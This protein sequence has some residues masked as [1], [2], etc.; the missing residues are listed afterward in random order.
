M[1]RRF[2]VAITAGLT[3]LLAQSPVAAVETE[4]PISHIDRAM[5]LLLAPAATERDCRDGFISLLDALTAVAPAAPSAEACQTRLSEARTRIARTSILDPQ[6]DTLIRDCYRDL[7]R[8]VPFRVPDGVRT[9]TEAVAYC[10]TGLESAKG[11]LRKGAGDEAFSRIL[12]VTILIVT[13][14]ERSDAKKKALIWLVGARW[15]AA[16]RSWY[17]EGFGWLSTER[18]SSSG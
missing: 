4:T 11:S 6:A 16:I 8:G 17:W 12:D 15:W 2:L 3:V 5:R 9:M 14:L 7:H 10:R 13:P 18:S 1:A